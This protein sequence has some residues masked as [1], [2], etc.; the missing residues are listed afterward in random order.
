MDDRVDNVWDLNF[1]PALSIP[2]KVF[3]SS[4]QAI[5]VGIC[6]TLEH[7]LFELETA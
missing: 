6:Q 5:K 7:K 2:P 3:N 1:P 4:F